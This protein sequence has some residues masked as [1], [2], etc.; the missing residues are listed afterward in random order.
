MKLPEDFERQMQDLL[1]TQR[2]ETFKD[3]LGQMPPVSIRRNPLKT[4]TN[5]R[6]GEETVPWCPNGVY[7]N[8]RPNFTFDPLLH[9]G[10]Y[11][12]QEASSMFI[13]QV[14]R[15]YANKPLTMLD[16]CAAPGGKS[17][18][19]RAALPA[20]SLLFCNEPMH[21]RA[22]ILV[23]NIQ[24]FGATDV[25]V[26][27]NYPKDYRKA[28][29]TF[30]IILCDVPCSGEGMFRKDEGAVAEWSLQKTDNCQRL[31]REIVG[32]AWECLAENGL[33]IYSTC[34][35]NTRENEEN[36]RWI[37]SKTG[38]EVLPV[39]TED[40]WNI[41]GS[42]LEGFDKP[43]YRF[44][45]GWTKGEGLFMAVLRKGAATHEKQE[46][47]NK[48]KQGKQKGKNGDLPA[49]NIPILGKEDFD[50]TQRGND[51]YAIPAA[52]RNEYDTASRLLKVMH[53][54]IKV[55]TLK[56]KD[57]VPD[58]S[59]ALSCALDREAFPNVSLDYAEAIGY[60][61]KEAVTLPPD[62]PCGI[63]LLTYGGHPIG[64]AKNIGRRANNLYPQEWRIRSTHIP[65][66]K[67]I[68]QLI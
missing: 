23:E 64:F 19:A 57:M 68:T 44:I 18:A 34:T 6:D 52:W 63:V 2:Y 32:D 56:G 59:L 11:Y 46:Q 1:G 30:D 67:T 45:P 27:N 66:E 43:V 36:I 5:G 47:G 15:Q 31:Q 24:K 13:D 16:L 58:Q 41:T 60:L 20:G 10:C 54:G 37:C 28:G 42:L 35:F 25:I 29:I 22:Q 4:T 40:D 48:K 9:A 49:H 33:L 61:R 38:A 17:T 39:Q 62:T 21:N 7:L 3:A 12:V 14:L 65:D 51:I 26:T 55:G 53:A 8:E 50:I